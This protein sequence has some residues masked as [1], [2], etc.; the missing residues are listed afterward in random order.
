[1]KL[2]KHFFLSL[3]FATVGLSVNPAQAQG[4]F[5]SQIAN[6]FVFCKLPKPCKLC[7]PFRAIHEQLCAAGKPSAQAQQQYQEATNNAQQNG[8]SMNAEDFQKSLTP[9]IQSAYNDTP[10]DIEIESYIGWLA[11]K[12][13]PAPNNNLTMGQYWTNRGITNYYNDASIRSGAINVIGE[14]NKDIVNA[15]SAG[16]IPNNPKPWFIQ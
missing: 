13:A 7:Q 3:T 12:A 2:I 4:V 15:V 5:N 9:A 10:T 14:V 8:N 11:K 16:R 6:P 1:M